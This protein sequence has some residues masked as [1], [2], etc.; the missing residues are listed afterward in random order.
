M[1]LHAD[2]EAF[3]ELVNA[4]LQPMSAMSPQQARAAYDRATLALDAPGPQVAAESLHVG[5]RDGARIATRLYRGSTAGG[6]QPLLL[7]F[8]GG[9]YVL[10]GLD[11]HDALCRTLAHEAGCAVL[12][13]DYRRAPE[14]RFPIAFHDAED[15]FAW[16]H[17]HGAEHGLDSNRLAV[18]GDSVGG[19][20]AT[21]LCIAAR[22]A[23]RPQPLI[24]LLLYPCTA[25][26]QDSDSHRRLASGWLLEHDNLQWM[27]RQYL[28]SDEDRRDWRFAPL[29]AA[30]LSRLAPTHLTLAE[31]D[32]LVD[33]GLRYAERLQAAGVPCEVQVHGG[34]V[35]DF[36]RLTNVVGEADA[37][38]RRLAQP[39]VRAFA[40]QA[41][42]QWSRQAV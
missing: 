11:S 4:Q 8:H 13:V 20:V 15:A 6:R 41:P 39:L 30:D 18:G 22:E 35:H 21:A 42:E 25:A 27:F 40:A 37:L 3:L 2:L 16:V 7:F 24:Q 23:A 28:R 26:W 1:P 9:G 31:Y 32:P 34:M 38:R 36:A 5:A 14:Y 17:A 33:E 10:G 12:A 29:E 19:T